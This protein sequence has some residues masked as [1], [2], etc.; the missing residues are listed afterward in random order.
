MDYTGDQC[1]WSESHWGESMTDF[2]SWTAEKYA[3]RCI[4][5][6]EAHIPDLVLAAGMATPQGA[7]KALGST[8]AG[9]GGAVAT[10]AMMGVGIFRIPSGD[11]VKKAVANNLIAVTEQRVYLFNA[12]PLITVTGDGV[13]WKRSEVRTGLRQG[14]VTWTITMYPPGVEALS[15]DLYVTGSAQPN[16]QVVALLMQ[17]PAA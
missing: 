9:I 8:L 17:N 10:T 2:M 12:S 14:A 15:F 3:A 11:T 1:A 5:Q 16:K 6:A 4:E 13:S 7:H